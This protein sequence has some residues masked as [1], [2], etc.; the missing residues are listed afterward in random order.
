MN[1]GGLFSYSGTAEL[2]SLRLKKKDV[3]IIGQLWYGAF[4]DLHFKILFYAGKYMLD[5]YH[6][7][8]Y[9][10]SDSSLQCHLLNVYHNSPIDIHR[11]RDMHTIPC[12][13]TSICAICRNML[14]NGVNAV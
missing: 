8:S 11:G 1:K 2:A 10:P 13:M 12:S 9:V 3:V 14:E 5:S 7:R 6:F 4:P